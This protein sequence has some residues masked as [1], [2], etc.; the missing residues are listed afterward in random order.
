MYGPADA[1]CMTC[2]D[3]QVSALDV[4]AGLNGLFLSGFLF[5][6]FSA[7]AVVISLPVEW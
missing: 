5:T 2:V 7:A 6:I 1:R 4:N 3:C